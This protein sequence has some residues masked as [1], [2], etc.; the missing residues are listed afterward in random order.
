MHHLP[1]SDDPLAASRKKDHIQLAFQSQTLAT[2]LDNRFFYEPLL[3]AH[4]EAGSWPPFSFLGKKM[5]V[6]LWV[7]SMTGGTAL[8]RHINQH[9]ARACGEFG[10]GMGLGSCRQLLFS[11]EYLDD[12]MVRPLIGDAYPL[13]ANLGIAQIEQLLAKGETERID[14][15]LHKLQA[16]GLIVHVNPM[17][18]WMQPE[19]D[20]LK[21]PPIDTIRTLLEN[22]TY[23]VIVKEVGQGMGWNSLRALLQLPLAA[24]DFGAAGG[25]NFAR[26]ELLR[27]TPQTAQAFQPLALTG[28]TFT[29]MTDMCNDLVRELGPNVQCPQLIISG[30]VKHYL[31]GFYAIKKSTLPAVYGQASAFLEHA[32]GDY[33]TLRQFV[34]IQIKG[35]EMANAYLYVRP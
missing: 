30:G 32:R 25:T 28:H 16:D 21:Y 31:D 6:P 11:D 27:S 33:D 7:S 34:Q 35:L 5:A 18:E 9:L 14:L 23:P 20:R 8:A 2:E 15:L 3:S 29:D 4:P 13:Y 22:A 24:I 12:F 1:E 17:Q 19:G 10:M 26:L